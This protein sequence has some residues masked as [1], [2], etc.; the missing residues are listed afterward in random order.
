MAIKVFKDGNTFEMTITDNLKDIKIVRKL[1]ELWLED[2]GVEEFK[3]M[4]VKLCVDEAV[5][6]GIIHAYKGEAHKKKVVEVRME[7]SKSDVKILI[8]DYGKKSWYKNYKK[9]D[10]TTVVSKELAPSH[11]R[12]IIIMQKLSKAFKISN[13]PSSGTRV[14]MTIDLVSNKIMI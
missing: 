13:I 1:I 7:K 12:G 5:Y 14:S 4:S 9:A 3:V 11:G 10:T 8:R 2:M 6:N